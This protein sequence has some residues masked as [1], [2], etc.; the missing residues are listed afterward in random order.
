MTVGRG[1]VRAMAIAALAG[2]TLLAAT[3]C[4]AR[5]TGS[6]RQ[7]TEQREEPEF[8][9]VRVGGVYEVRIT[10]GSPPSVSV[11]ADDNLLPLIATDVRGDRLVI[12]TKQQFN[13]RGGRPVVTITMPRLTEVEASGASSV[14]VSGLRAETLTA[15][16]SG[17]SAIQA[18]GTT[19]R[20]TVSASGSSSIRMADL[21]ANVVDARASG[22]SNIQ[23]QARES[24]VAEASG[25]STISYSGSPGQ[26]RVESSGASNITRR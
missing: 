26:T 4:E 6:G 10:I 22:A 25:A 5:V 12:D 16:V 14:Q 24:L 13:A 15:R 9:A 2:L 20:L 21:N 1:R 8:T 3:G 17:A 23:V 7:V 18:S 11:T 19:G